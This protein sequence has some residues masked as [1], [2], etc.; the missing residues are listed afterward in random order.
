MIDQVQRRG[1]RRYRL[2]RRVTVSSIHVIVIHDGHDPHYCR[3]R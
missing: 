2:S 1:D 3:L